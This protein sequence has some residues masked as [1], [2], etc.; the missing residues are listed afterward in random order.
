MAPKHLSK[1]KAKRTPPTVLQPPPS[2]DSPAPQTPTPPIPPTPSQPAQRPPRRDSLDT[3]IFSDYYGDVRAWNAAWEEQ[4]ARVFAPG[5]KVLLS[6]QTAQQQSRHL[7]EFMFNQRRKGWDSLGESAWNIFEAVGFCTPD[8]ELVYERWRGKTL[9]EREEIVLAALAGLHSGDSKLDKKREINRR[10]APEITLEGMAGGGGQGFVRLVNAVLPGEKSSYS[11]VCNSAFERVYGFRADGD[12][13]LAPLS[14]R[15][16]AWQDEELLVRASYLQGF[17]SRA[18]ELIVSILS[19]AL[20]NLWTEL[21]LQTGKT[22]HATFEASGVATPANS[23]ILAAGGCFEGMTLEEFNSILKPHVP[24]L[25]C[26][27]C[28][29]TGESGLS[30]LVSSRGR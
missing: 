22:V 26:E 8:S 16:R 6:E 29:L 5:S 11:I 20:G 2:T 24:T 3:I 18:L 7:D 14:K 25:K 17:V 30:A 12:E 28:Y 27:C 10:S 4:N 1:S 19:R 21:S 23:P 9:E 13:S 15:L